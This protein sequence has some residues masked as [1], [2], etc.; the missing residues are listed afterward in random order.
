MLAHKKDLLIISK[1]DKTRLEVVLQMKIKE[2]NVNMERKDKERIKALLKLRHTFEES[3]KREKAQV[4]ELRSFYQKIGGSRSDS[5]SDSDSGSGN[6][7]Q[8]GGSMMTY[9]TPF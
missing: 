1:R 7:T 9:K 3:R 8:G 4:G 2:H 5:E 6:E